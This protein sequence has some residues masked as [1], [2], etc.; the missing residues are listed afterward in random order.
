[1]E[2]I[3]LQ[4]MPMTSPHMLLVTQQQ[5]YYKIYLILPKNCLLG[6]LKIK[7]KHTMYLIMSSLEEDAAIQIEESTIKCSKLKNY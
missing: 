6:L 3:I 7:W 4:I 2:T 5:K 1:M